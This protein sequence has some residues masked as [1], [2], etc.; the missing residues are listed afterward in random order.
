MNRFLDALRT[1]AKC[2]P[3]LVL[4]QFAVLG[5]QPVTGAPEGSSALIPLKLSL[6]DAQRTAFQRNWD[7]LAAKS[8]ID[9]A[10]AQLLVAKEFPNPT[11][12]FSTARIDPSG[13]GTPV[14]ND[15]SSRTYDTIFAISQL[16]YISGKRHSRQ[17]SGR[18]SVVS[19]RARVF[20]ARRSL[21]HGVTKAYVAAL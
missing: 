16:V 20:D 5:A 2:W 1:W 10:N 4:A 19:A 7:L 18:A 11:F 3:A 6:A 17:L 8:G 12:S 14:G 21:D 9:L 13:N 15:I